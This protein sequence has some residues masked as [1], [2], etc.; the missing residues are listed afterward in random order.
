MIENNDSIFYFSD[1]LENEQHDFKLKVF[2]PLLRYLFK[3]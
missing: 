1:S 3:K 2:T